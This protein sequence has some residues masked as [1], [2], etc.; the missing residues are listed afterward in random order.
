MKTIVC[1]GDSNTWGYNVTGGRFSK[2]IRWTSCLQ[3]SL[4]EEYFIGEE[5]LNGRTTIFNDAYQEERNGERVLP[6][7]LEKYSSIDIL[8]LMLGTNDCKHQY[9]ADE[10]RIGEG[11]KR[12]IRLAK[13]LKKSIQK[14]LVIAPDSIQLDKNGLVEQE[15]NQ[16]VSK[17][18]SQVYLEVA[19]KEGCAFL[20]ADQWVTMNEI[21]GIHL[22]KEG[23]GVLA[24]VIESKLRDLGWI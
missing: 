22:T 15:F 9:K 14:I 24:Q 21:D 12:L 16:V 23:H 1:F 5:G 7:I 18:L 20:D 10:L 13:S 4:G 6:S 8:L 19:Q 2:K 11:M 17:K 3:H